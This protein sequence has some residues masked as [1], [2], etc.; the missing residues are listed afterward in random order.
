MAE[1]TDKDIE[2]ALRAAGVGPAVLKGSKAGPT[3]DP[4]V[5]AALKAAGVPLEAIDAPH[6][7]ERLPEPSRER[8]P[9]AEQAAA[10]RQSKDL[11]VMSP[12]VSGMP[13]IGPATQAAAAATGAAGVGETMPGDSFSERFGKNY[14]VLGEAQRLYDERH[15]VWSPVGGFI[16]SAAST[17][18][19][20]AA[21]P[22]GRMVAG[23]GIGPTVGW[24][25]LTGGAGGAGLGALDEYLRGGSALS[26]AEI[27][28]GFGAAGP[29]VGE[30]ARGVSRFASDQMWPR[31]GPL[32]KVNPTAIHKL[33]GAFEGETPASIAAGRDRAG[34]AGMMADVSTGMTDIAGGLAD[35]PGPQKQV[36]R[37]AVRMRDAQSKARIDAALNTHITNKTNVE[38]FKNFLTENRAAAADP[39]YKQFRTTEVHPTPEIQAILPRLEEAGA[40]A[41]GEKFA[42]IDG[43]PFDK[44]F[45]APGATKRFPTAESWSYIKQGLN[46]LI[47]KAY[48]GGDKTLARKLIGLKRDMWTE[49][50][51]APGGNIL[52]QADQ[53]FKSRSDIIDQ[54]A[55]GKDTFLGGRHGLTVD[56]LRDELR[57]LSGP[58]LQARIVGLRQA[59][60]DVF[61]ATHIGDTSLRNKILAPNNQ[62][63]IKLMLGDQRGEALIKEM[64]REKFLKEQSQNIVGGSQT[65]PKK[66]RVDALKPMAGSEWGFDLAKPA[67]WPP[68]SFRPSHLIDSLRQQSHGTSMNQLGRIVTTPEGP[69]MG[70]LIDAVHTEMARRAAM[71]RAV[72]PGA[73]ALSSVLAVPGSAAARR[74]ARD[75]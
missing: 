25:A 10:E 15:P 56:E 64:E 45:F 28:G 33:V 12:V 42:K 13:V 57:G 70:N 3:V 65:T 41:M 50:K 26:G 21:G 69:E 2:D 20:G 9:P 27:G 11:G 63:K 60:D 30:G 52:A 23:G 73:N 36:V 55:A 1:V 16:G 40:L 43:V 67:T 34:G 5:A 37:E 46:G 14:G 72:A 48:S 49:L 54:I 18:P 47:D 38:D 59:A 44:A 32:A 17:L 7:K 66:E 62:A 74:G 53:E 58:E 8:L 61:G 75:Q 51:K 68:P 22:V 29:I 35:T 39:L 31:G 71:D 19:L 6:R 4:D 24:R